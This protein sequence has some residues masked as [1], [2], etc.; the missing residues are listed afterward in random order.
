MTISAETATHK[1]FRNQNTK[2]KSKIVI[3]NLSNEQ[4]MADLS[5]VENKNSEK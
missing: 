1:Q 3:T 2:K 5:D 4:N